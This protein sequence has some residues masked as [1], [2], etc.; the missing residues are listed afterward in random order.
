MENP[1]RA[2]QYKD[3][4]FGSVSLN[5]FLQA[6]WWFRKDRTMSYLVLVVFPGHVSL[7]VVGDTTG[8]HSCE[9]LKFICSLQ[10]TQSENNS[11]QKGNLE[12]T[13][14]SCCWIIFQVR[15]NFK[16]RS[17]CSGSHCLCFEHLQGWWCCSVSCPWSRWLVTLI[18]KI[19]FPGLWS[20][21]LL[22]LVMSFVFCHITVH[23]PL[24][25]SMRSL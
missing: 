24:C 8:L 16:V 19:S 14:S 21:L 17:G 7:A 11:G 20:E 25:L 6:G 5:Q 13:C 9:Y 4:T 2:I 18:V 3:T 22:L 23:L 15:F 1:A 12:G 10:I